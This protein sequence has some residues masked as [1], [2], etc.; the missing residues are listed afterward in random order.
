MSVAFGIVKRKID[1]FSLVNNFIAT[2]WLE[3]P[4]FKIR[5]SYKFA[6]EVVRNIKSDATC[7][8]K[9][10]YVCKA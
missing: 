6:E 7:A 5:F 1:K 9:F 2:I 10:V 4:C 3:L 8:G